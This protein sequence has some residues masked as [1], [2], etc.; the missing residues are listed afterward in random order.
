MKNRY[1]FVPLVFLAGFCFL[2]AAGC[3]TLGGGEINRV[4]ML[5]EN[6]I[7]DQTW[8][9]KGYQGLLKIKEEYD[10]DV[11]FK[12]GIQTQ[13]DVNRAVEEFSNQG[14]NL[15][16]G[17]SSNYGKMFDEINEAY[18][19]IHFVYFNGGYTGDNLTSVNFNSHAMG[20]FSGMVAGKMTSTNNVGLIG[21]F[22]WQP[23]IEGFYEGVNYQNPEADVHMNFVNSWDDS[24]RALD[25]LDQMSTQDVDVFY[26]TGDQFSVQVI[27]KVKEKGLYAIGYVT[28]QASLGKNTVL[29]STVQHVDDIY[30]QTAEAFNEGNLTG[31][32]KTYD[33]QDGGITM[34]EFSPEVPESFVEEIQDAI[35]R[36]K[37]TGLLPNEQ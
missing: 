8:G 33:F 28:D 16:F 14:I 18:P 26:P 1:R 24:G 22:E 10:V 17:H 20:F 32:V 25:L 5:V 13:Q 35:D 12:E 27:N 4:G 31:D 34:G 6:S 37:D 19:D 21:A 15:I 3:S 9:N 2:L 29:T 7:H 23:E 36:Y 11:Y 30:L